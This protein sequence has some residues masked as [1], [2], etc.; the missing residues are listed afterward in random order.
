MRKLLSMVAAAVLFSSAPIMAE[1]A[2][3]PD[4]TPGPDPRILCPWMVSMNYFRNEGD[5]MRGFRVGGAAMCQQLER[6]M[7]DYLGYRNAGECVSAMREAER[8]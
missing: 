5:C 4:E 7:L 2:P 1:P 8:R 6:N 3:A